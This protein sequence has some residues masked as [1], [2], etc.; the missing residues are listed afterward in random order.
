ME[1]VDSKRS[2]LLLGL[3]VAKQNRSE[4]HSQLVHCH[5]SME[6]VAFWDLPNRFFYP[7]YQPALLS[8]VSL[9]HFYFHKSPCKNMRFKKIIN[10]YQSGICY[11]PRKLACCETKIP[12]KRE[13]REG[14]T[15]EFLRNN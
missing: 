3:G 6:R 4:N 12:L 7:I 15:A 5:K 11:Q 9:V 1:L 14:R 13:K 2:L 8:L 10:N